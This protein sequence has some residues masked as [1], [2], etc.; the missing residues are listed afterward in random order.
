MGVWR[1]C[2]GREERVIATVIALG[3]LLPRADILD[4]QRPLT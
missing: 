1:W 3:K 2:S 4:Q